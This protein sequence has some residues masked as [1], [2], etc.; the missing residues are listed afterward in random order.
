MFKP[1]FKERIWGGSR[2]HPKGHIGEAWIVSDHPEGKTPIINGV[3]S[4]KYLNE[5]MQTHQEWFSTLPLAKFPLLVKLLDADDDLSVQVHPSDEYAM[6][7][8]HGVTGKT[9]CWYIIDAKPGAEIILGHNAKNRREF[10]ALARAQRWDE[11]LVRVPVKAG[12]FFFIPSGTVHALGK[13]IFLLEVQQNSDTTY[14]IYDYDRVGLDGHK[15]ALHIEK[16]LD[17]IDF[18]TEKCHIEPCVVSKDNFV[19]TLLISSN[20]FTVEKWLVDSMHIFHSLKVFV[21]IYIVAGKGQLIYEDGFIQLT[22]GLSL[23]I[24]ANMGEYSIQG[25]I[26]AIVCH[27]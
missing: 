16:A 24:P 23:M 18:N 2:L 25:S 15:R 21:L 11:L 19:K 1:V 7:N 17:V 20:Y 5:V 27:I 6:I 26:E 22:E 8:E 13:G 12:D 14:R 3:L 10:L 9:E 4:G